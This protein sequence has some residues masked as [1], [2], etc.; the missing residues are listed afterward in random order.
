M[1]SIHDV[2]NVVVHT[3][4]ALLASFLLYVVYDGAVCGNPRVNRPLA[5]PDAETWR[6]LMQWGQTDLLIVAVEPA[7]LPGPW[8]EDMTVLFVM[9]RELGP[10]RT[11]PWPALRDEMHTFLVRRW[12]LLAQLLAARGVPVELC[13]RVARR[14]GQ[15]F[16]VTCLALREPLE[17]GAHALG[18]CEVP[19]RALKPRTVHDMKNALGRDK[20]FVAA[21][22]LLVK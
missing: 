8:D 11:Q 20:T 14:L 6:A 10:A 9:L 17:T 13:Q 19:R 4:L 1:A 2:L 22:N 21:W 12:W 5:A 16:R 15:L 7:T 18:L 3:A